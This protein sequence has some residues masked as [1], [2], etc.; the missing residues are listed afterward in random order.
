M[1]PEALHKDDYEKY[2]FP[3]VKIPLNLDKQAKNF[4]KFPILAP[5]INVRLVTLD[6]P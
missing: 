5:K 4:A 6:F 1:A 3:S 2:V